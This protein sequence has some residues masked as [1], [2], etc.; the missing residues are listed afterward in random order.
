MKTIVLNLKNNMKKVGTI[1]FGFHGK[2]GFINN[3]I[4]DKNQRKNGFGT[5]LLK[6]S[7]ESLK[8]IYKVEHIKLCAWNSIYSRSSNLDFYIKNGYEING[9]TSYYDNDCD[10]FEIQG[11]IKNLHVVVE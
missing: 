10:I 6:L 7:E 5:E 4:V 3:I 8:N 1:S 2:T 9:E 11:L